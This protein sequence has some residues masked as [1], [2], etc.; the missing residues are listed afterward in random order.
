M[1]RERAKSMDQS[2]FWTVDEAGPPGKRH[3]PS[4]ASREPGR[5]LA[6]APFQGFIRGMS[7]E[8]LWQ[9]IFS[10]TSCLPPKSVASVKASWKRLR[11]AVWRRAAL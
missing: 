4:M 9:S 3:R 8:W 1:T 6:F 11:E 2:S 10:A 5:V 7:V